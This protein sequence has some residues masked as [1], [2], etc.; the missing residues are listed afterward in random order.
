MSGANAEI[1]EASLFA[2]VDVLVREGDGMPVEVGLWRVDS[3][4]PQRMNST[5]IE[6]EKQLE[7]LIEQDPAIL[8]YP[9]LIIGRQVPTKTGGTVDLLGMDEEGNL[10]VLDQQTLEPE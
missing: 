10:H 6:L 7:E 9:L 5:G 8:G 1:A 3:G 4:R 2:R